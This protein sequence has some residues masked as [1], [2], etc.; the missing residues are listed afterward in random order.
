ML[1]QNIT[2][3]NEYLS[4]R[5][6]EDYEIVLCNDGSPDTC[7]DI[8]QR[9]I[10]K[11]PQVVSIGYKKNHGRGYALKYAGM[12]AKGDYFICMDCDLA[13]EENMPF[14][15]QMIE[16]VK[17]HDVVIASRFLPDSETKRKIIRRVVSKSYRILVKLMFRNFA[18]T[19]P[20]VG[21]KG[22]K[23]DVFTHINLVTNLNGPSWDLQFLINADAEQHDIIEFPFHYKEDYTSTTVSVLSCSIIEFLGMV[24]VKFTRIISDYIVF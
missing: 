3:F 4:Q 9:L 7:W 15:E 19:D 17:N 20:D 13:T 18:V 22:F 12:R 10:N 2:F 8:A 23:K 1:E 21:F 5:M 16:L 14:V 24:Y 11:S 6:P